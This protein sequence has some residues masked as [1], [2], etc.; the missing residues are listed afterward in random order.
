VIRGPLTRAGWT[1]WSVTT[2]C[3]APRST[4]CQA[5]GGQ[6]RCRAVFDALDAE[7]SGLWRVR[8]AK[9]SAPPVGVQII[10]AVAPR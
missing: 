2:L 5:T 1:G 10:V 3:C 7:Q 8:P 6:V 9:R 4:G